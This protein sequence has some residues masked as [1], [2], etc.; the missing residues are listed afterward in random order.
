[1]CISLTNDVS[2]THLGF[3]TQGMQQ[4]ALTHTVVRHAIQAPAAC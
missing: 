2:N 1:M 4:Y 3:F